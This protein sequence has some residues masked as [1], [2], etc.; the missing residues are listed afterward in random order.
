M[1]SSLNSGDVILLTGE[2]GS[3]KTT[4]VKGLADGMGVTVPVKSPTFNII[5]IY[6]GGLPLYHIDLYR[7]EK[8]R[9]LDDIDLDS[10][11]YDSDGICVIEWGERLEDLLIDSYI[12]VRF[13]YDNGDRRR[14][15]VSRV[16]PTKRDPF[17][18]E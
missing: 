3:G 7:L 9:E 12:S 6:K 13:L 15:E 5:N 11:L 1:A 14:I 10:Y 16:F 17:Q 2:L 8:K 18:R 4:F